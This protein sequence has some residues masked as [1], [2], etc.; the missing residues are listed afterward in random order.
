MNTQTK[1]Y[2]WTRKDQWLYVISMIP[3]IIVFVGTAYLLA[4]HSILLLAILLALFLLT[5][6]FQAGCCVGCPYRGKYCPALCGVYLGNWLS[7][8]L[9]KKREFDEHFFKL[10]ATAG[11]T[12]VFVLILYPLYWIALTNW[13]F[14]PIYL[15]LIALHFII[16][17]PIQCEKC[18]YNETCPG[19]QTW[20]KCRTL[21]DRKE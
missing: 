18:S 9:Y 10:N 15:G 16:F 13:L 12:M 1:T 3:F 7:N 19:G 14:V 8:I 21:L 6:V 11:E 4:T 17:M 20:H 2:E 5:N